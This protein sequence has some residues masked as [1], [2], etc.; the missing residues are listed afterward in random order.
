[1]RDDLTAAET[2]YIS[3]TL[4]RAAL[5]AGRTVLWHGGSWGR[6]SSDQSWFPEM[7]L[8]MA[9]TEYQCRVAVWWITTRS[10]SQWLEEEDE[11][12]KKELEIPLSNEQQLLLQIRT[13]VARLQPASDFCCHLTRAVPTGELEI[14]GCR[15][16]TTFEKT[17]DQ[18]SSGRM[19]S[20]A[21][22]GSR[23][24]TMVVHQAMSHGGG[25]GGGHLRRR[26]S[27]LRGSRR[28]LSLLRSSEDNNRSDDMNFYGQFKHIRATLD[29]T[30]HCNYTHERQRFQDAI[31]REYL[32]EAIVKDRNGEVCTTPTEPWIVFTAGAMGAGYVEYIMV[33][34]LQYLTLFCCRQEGV[35]HATTGRERPVSTHCLCTG[36]PGC[37]SSLPT[38]VCPVRH[39]FSRNGGRVDQQGSGV[40]CRNLDASRTAGRQECY[41]RRVATTIRVVQGIL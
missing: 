22:N 10:E 34:L 17:F 2:R 41:C 25:A 7:F 28:R 32:E 19:D 9:R 35:H 26:S 12:K 30:Y 36:R 29:Y 11:R 31:I 24:T 39:E 15:F 16:W 18:S 5:A 14:R 23:T 3:E 4:V 27:L 21:M 37:H 40:H 20:S 38:R 33:C 6:R 13:T 1:V 8:P